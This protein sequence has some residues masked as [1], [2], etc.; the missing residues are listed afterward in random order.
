MS[1]Q[2]VC[3]MQRLLPVVPQVL[4]PNIV[5][6]GEEIDA[7]HATPHSGALLHQTYFYNPL[8]PHNTLPVDTRLRKRLLNIAEIESPV[9]PEGWGC[10]HPDGRRNWCWGEGIQVVQALASPEPPRN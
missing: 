7:I 1:M 2:A 10:H 4:A 3:E 5:R 9:K 8:Q 6:Q